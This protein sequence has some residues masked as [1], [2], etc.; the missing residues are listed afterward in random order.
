MD[1]LLIKKHHTIYFFSDV[2]DADMIFVSITNKNE[3]NI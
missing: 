2:V 1:V 3:K